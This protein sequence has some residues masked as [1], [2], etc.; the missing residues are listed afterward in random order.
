MGVG[1]AHFRVQ[2]SGALGFKRVLRVRVHGST[3]WP[4]TPRLQDLTLWNTGETYICRS[5]QH[6]IIEPRRDPPKH[7]VL[8]LSYGPVE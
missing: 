5:N 3:V 1:F 6:K 2:G 8:M 4:Q 7:H